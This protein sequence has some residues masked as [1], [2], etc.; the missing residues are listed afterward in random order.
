MQDPR[1]WR[2]ERPANIYRLLEAHAM[3]RPHAEALI[4]EDARTTF[5][6]LKDR[7]DRIAAALI[8]SGVVRGDR[9]ALLAP[10]GA[11]FFEI[12]LATVS[13]GAVWVGLNP[14]YKER[15]YDYLLANATP[16][17][18][19]AQSPFDDRNY[20]AELQ[21]IGPDVETFVALGDA[22][23]RAIDWD[24]FLARGDGVDGTALANARSA[25]DGE[26]TAVIV[27]TS[28]TTGHPKGAMLSHRA[29]VACALC[30]V[31]WMG[32]GLKSTIMCAPINHV[33]G[34]N[35]V[36]MNVF[37]YGG[38]IIFHERVDL[39]KIA[40]LSVKESP[41]Y[42]VASPT[43]FVMMLETPGFDIQALN[44]Y[45]L[46]VFGGA[47][48]PEPVL[49]QITPCGAKM[50]SVYGQTETCGIVTYT[51]IG[52]TTKVMAE[53]IGVALPGATIRIA[54]ADDR[55]APTGETG[56]IQA[57]GPYCMSGYFNMPEATKDAFTADGYLRTGDLG[58]RRED[59]NIEFVSRLKEMFKS[60][61]YNVYPLEVEQALCEH[62]DVLAAAVMPVPDPKFQEVGHAYLTPAPGKDIDIENVRAFLKDT[63]ANYKA[64]KT[65]E[66]LDAMPLLPNSK[67][68]RRALKERA[69]KAQSG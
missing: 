26:D 48:T 10:P 21:S 13:I 12:Y 61:G 14:K 39:A 45:E 67:L 65:Y 32:D 30:N 52:S 34:L 59:G 16:R 60:G 69:L 47:T 62:P 22:E 18:V 31:G 27:Y 1:D 53:T 33:G 38:A 51:P 35:N 58:R 57:L 55:E 6:V 44:F 3:H 43:A 24:A 29:I 2:G 42:L 9:V 40:E 54:D 50:S 56:E 68:D 49:D 15:E 46:I 23:G 19:I 7:V 36:C 20:I 17:V 28:G 41:T 4:E 5:D 8:A 37:A 66:I 25:V 64:P 11:A 63:I